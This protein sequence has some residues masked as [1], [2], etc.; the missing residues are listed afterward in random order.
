MDGLHRLPHHTHQV[1]A[2]RGGVGF[3]GLSSVV[4][5][6]IE[7]AIHQGLN[8]SPQGVE[9]SGDGE[10]RGHDREG[11]LLAR[12]SDE[13]PLQHD[14]ANEVECDQRDG[15]R[16]I[17]EG[18]VDDNVYV[19]EAIAKDGYPNRDRDGRDHGYENRITGPLEPEGRVY[20]R[21]YDVCKE[22]ADNCCRSCVS[23]PFDLLTLYPD[24]MTQAHEH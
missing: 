19:V 23:E 3:Q 8:T 21:R 16:A 24:G 15:K 7:T 13:H 20:H 9:Q 10:G 14:D 5:L 1:V 17:D 12:E 18:T 2:Q 22:E 6:A 11:G 4:L